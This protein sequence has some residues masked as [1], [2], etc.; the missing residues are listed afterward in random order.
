MSYTGG[1]CNKI[2]C[3]SADIHHALNDGQSIS[4]PIFGWKR[5]I[6]FSEIFDIEYFNRSVFEL[7]GFD[8]IICDQ[9]GTKRSDLWSKSE[10]LVYEQRQSNILSSK[11]ALYITLVSL[12]PSSTIIT[13]MTTNSFEIGIHMRLESD[14]IPYATR[15]ES[16]NCGNIFLVNES[17]ISHM[18]KEMFGNKNTI[19]ISTGMN[20]DRVVENLK[21]NG[22]DDDIHFFHDKNLEYEQNAYLNFLT[23]I[24]CNVFVGNSRSTFSNLVT[25]TRC[26][27]QNNNNYIYNTTTSKLVKRADFGIH[28]DPEKVENNVVMFINERSENL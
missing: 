19:F 25:M 2:F 26:I 14:W 18:I 16:T 7:T 17:T 5:K 28:C 9:L 20:H 13:H 6:K 22:L 15:K 3:L 1:L 12:K 27:Q 23:L 24:N 10:S 11:D 4:E 21:C 8:K